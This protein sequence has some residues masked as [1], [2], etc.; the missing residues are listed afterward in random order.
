MTSAV[1]SCWLCV[2]IVAKVGDNRG[3]AM[4]VRC[5]L[6]VFVSSTG[7]VYMLPLVFLVVHFLV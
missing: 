3:C 2:D 4:R 5:C 7:F 6:V 1:I